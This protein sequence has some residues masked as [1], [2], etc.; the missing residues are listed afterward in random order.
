VRSCVRSCVRLD[1][2]KSIDNGKLF[3]CFMTNAL[4]KHTQWQNGKKKRK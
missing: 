4:I 2:M 1:V 3:T